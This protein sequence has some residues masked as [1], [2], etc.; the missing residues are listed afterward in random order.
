MTPIRVGLIG[1]AS[2]PPDKYEGTAWASISHLPYFKASPDFDIVALL[3]SSEDAAKAAIQK[4][5]LPANTKAYGDPSGRKTSFPECNG[6]FDCL[7]NSFTAQTSQRTKMLISWSP[8]Y[9]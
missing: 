3:N 5:E 2:G 1:L 6:F 8:V 9:G 4:Y 7:A